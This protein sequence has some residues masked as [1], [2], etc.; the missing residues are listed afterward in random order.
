MVPTSPTLRSQ[1]SDAWRD[2]SAPATVLLAVAIELFGTECL[3]WEPETL[4][5]QLKSTLDVAPTQREMDRYLALVT[6]LTTN[7]IYTDV[8][9]FH[10]AMNA[11]NGSTATFQTWDPVTL[12]ELT[13][14]LTELELND[15]AGPDEKWADRFSADVRRYIGVLSGG[16]AAPHALPS[17]I[18][19][20][21]D[22]GAD[23]GDIRDFASDPEISGAAHDSVAAA[24]ADAE[25]YAKAT[26]QAVITALRSLPLSSRSPTWPPSA[27]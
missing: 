16:Y 9:A 17:V 18:K 2:S 23:T 4:R 26:L 19:D 25:A 15:R 6:A 13:W 10:H 21:A 27:A 7:M 1:L 14:G 20:V 11:L 8:Y 3:D 5:E 22:F 24:T 12:E